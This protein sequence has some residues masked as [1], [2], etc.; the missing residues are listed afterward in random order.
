V[1]DALSTLR[2]VDDPS[3]ELS[4]VAAL[5]SPLYACS[6]VDLFTYRRAGGRWDLRREPGD[7][8]EADHPVRLALEHLRSLWELRWWLGPAALLDRLL[9]DRHAQLLGFGDPRPKEVWHRLRFLL[10]QAREFEESGGGGL[11][12]FVDWA[13]LQ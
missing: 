9:R 13:E 8:V 4:L 1:R 5:R 2:A 11:R 12:A 3:D 7:G 6:D 10:D